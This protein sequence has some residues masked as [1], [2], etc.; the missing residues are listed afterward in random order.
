ME[1]LDRLSGLTAAKTAAIA[2]YSGYIE[3]GDLANALAGGVSDFLKKARP[4]VQAWDINRDGALGALEVLTE[5]ERSMQQVK[6]Q[7]VAKARLN[8][9]TPQQIASH[10]G[11]TVTA[12]E[13]LYPAAAM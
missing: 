1:T 2:T 6:A 3:A 12:L 5:L 13:Q 8:G 10:I 9:A 4:G 7:E 11:L